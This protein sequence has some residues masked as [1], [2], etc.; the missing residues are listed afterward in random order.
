MYVIGIMISSILFGF[1]LAWII[2]LLFNWAVV[3]V[4]PGVEPI[5]YWKTWGILL[6]ASLIKWLFF[7]NKSS[8]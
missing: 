3:G 4:I 8:E 2:Q 6:L 5:G 1:F 7:T